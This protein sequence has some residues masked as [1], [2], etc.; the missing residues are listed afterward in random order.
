MTRQRDELKKK[1]GFLEVR[2]IELQEANM[3]LFNL[4][5]KK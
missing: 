5:E 4:L 2:I 1:N 3:E